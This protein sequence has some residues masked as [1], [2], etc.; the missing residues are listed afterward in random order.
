ML[1]LFNNLCEATVKYLAISNVHCVIEPLQ[2]I[3]RQPSAFFIQLLSRR[4]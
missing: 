2:E 4:R 1:H 3:K